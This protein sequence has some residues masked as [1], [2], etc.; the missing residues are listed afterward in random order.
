MT[1]TRAPKQ[2]SIYEPYSV[3][4]ER[5]ER[6]DEPVIYEYDRFPRE[7]RAQVFHILSDVIGRARRPVV[8]MDGGIAP[9]AVWLKI[10]D[11]IARE[12]GVFNLHEPGEG[13]QRFLST[14]EKQLQ[15]YLVYNDEVQTPHMIDAIEIAF[16]FLLAYER[17]ISDYQ[18]DYASLMTPRGGV[19]EL[20]RRFRQHKLGYSYDLESGLIIRVDSEYLHTEAV[21]RSFHLLRRAG[22]KNA[23]TEF[24]KAHEHYCHGRYEE[25]MTDALKAFESAMKYICDDRQWPYDRDRHTAKPL[26]DIIFDKQL[27]PGWA[28]SQVT[29]LRSMLESGLPTARNRSAGH[30]RGP[31]AR[32]VTD[33]LAAFALHMTAANTVLLVEAFNA[34]P[35]Q[36][37]RTQ[38]QSDIEPSHNAGGHADEVPR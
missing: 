2:Q 21:I 15:T 25:A 23:E 9:S 22:F 6:G 12:R 38:T 3:R 1:R 11:G 8:T 7:F 4:L 10:H 34:L 14:K 13:L 32:Q 20:N 26:I 19:E 29:S 31:D 16:R 24:L 27:I 35:P 36:N 18:R 17:A 33:Y 28:Q 30:G 5:L 37:Q